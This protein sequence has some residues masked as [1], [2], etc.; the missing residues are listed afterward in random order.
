MHEDVLVK[1]KLMI[2]SLVA[3]LGL[4]GSDR[5]STLQ[6]SL[7][8]LASNRNNQNN[9]PII[10]YS[11]EIYNNLAKAMDAKY[12]KWHMANNDIHNVV[13]VSDAFPE[14]R[15]IVSIAL[16]QRID[17]ESDSDTFGQQFCY[18]GNIVNQL[19]EFKS[20]DDHEGFIKLLEDYK[21]VVIFNMHG[22]GDL[23]TMRRN[24]NEIQAVLHNKNVSLLAIVGPNYYDVDIEILCDANGVKP[25][26]FN[27]PKTGIIVWCKKHWFVS[28]A[29]LIALFGMMYHY[30]HLLIKS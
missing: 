9:A 21:G 24:L 4:Q 8:K 25:T 12:M 10:L 30:R 18:S 7:L 13:I 1:I 19:T 17:D 15:K 3:V 11:G 6:E 2:F 26:V 23:P 22:G 29:S 16:G 5:P 27:K 14:E 20:S 28:S